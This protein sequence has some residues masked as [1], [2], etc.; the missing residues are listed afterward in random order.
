[1]QDE[2]STVVSHDEVDDGLAEEQKADIV[3]NTDSIDTI[4]THDVEDDNNS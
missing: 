1:M 2:L 3:T 4:N